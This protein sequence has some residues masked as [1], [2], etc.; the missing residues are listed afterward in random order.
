[1]K[2]SRNLSPGVRAEL[3]VNK[4]FMDFIQESIKRFTKKDWGTITDE[5]KIENNKAI[6]SGEGI[7]GSY[8]PLKEGLKEIVIIVTKSRK[9][10]HI[11]F[12]KE[13]AAGMQSSKFKL[14]DTKGKLIYQ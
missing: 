14:Y 7:V 11:M 13:I 12:E 4:G 8:M 3:R 10:M 2:L 5:D 6:E 9:Y 1:M